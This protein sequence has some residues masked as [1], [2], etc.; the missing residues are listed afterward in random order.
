M[1]I[2]PA[3]GVIQMGLRLLLGGEQIVGLTSFSAWEWR[4]QPVQLEQVGKQRAQ[5]LSGRFLSSL[6]ARHSQ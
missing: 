1:T 5:S 6:L 3:V 4:W 2:F